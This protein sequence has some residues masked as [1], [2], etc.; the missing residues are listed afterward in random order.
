MNITTK[1]ASVL[2][3][4]GLMALGVASVSA[5]GFSGVS[6][7]TPEEI[8][9]RQTSMF[10]KQATMLGATVDEV[11]NA[12]AEGKDMRTLAKE[13]GITED[14]LQAK[15][16]AVRGEQMKTHIIALVSSGVITQA[17]ADKRLAFMQ[18][19][20]T[21]KKAGGMHKRGHGEMSTQSFGF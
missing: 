18:T 14:Q 16:K 2:G 12:W 11:K 3:L 1:K 10:Q 15:M 8:A 6:T 21:N 13:K 20:S 5:I 9:T 19:R 4:L 17:Q 7:V